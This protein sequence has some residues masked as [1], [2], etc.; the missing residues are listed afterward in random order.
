MGR[1]HLEKCMR[2]FEPFK[3]NLGIL[4]QRGL[5]GGRMSFGNLVW[6]HEATGK[7]IQ[8]LE[9]YFADPLLKNMRIKHSKLKLGTSQQGTESTW[10]ELTKQF[11]LPL[12]FGEEVFFWFV[13]I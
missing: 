10:T 5:F 3:I 6:S 13:W 12:C 11:L 1:G 4:S 9:M 8:N 2:I 7:T